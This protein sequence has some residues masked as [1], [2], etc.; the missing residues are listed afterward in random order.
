[1]KFRNYFIDG[2]GNMWKE[3]TLINAAKDLPVFDFDLSKI[4][5]D[6]QILWQTNR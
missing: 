4:S 2:K 1:M 5:Q 6:E 3:K